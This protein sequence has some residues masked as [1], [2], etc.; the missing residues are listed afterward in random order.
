MLQNGH[1]EIYCDG[2]N[3]Y[4]IYSE[5]KSTILVNMKELLFI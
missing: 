1:I 5:K 4:C 2:L 3:I